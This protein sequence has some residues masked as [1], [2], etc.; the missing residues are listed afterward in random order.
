MQKR[1][2]IKRT[3]QATR[4]RRRTQICRVYQLKLT[5]NKLRRATRAHL[6][7]LFQE[8]KWF[9]NWALSGPD[10]FAID[11]TRKTVPVKVGS[12]F[13]ERPLRCLSSQMKQGLVTQLHHAVSALITLKTQGQKV[14]RLK[15]KKRV[16]CIPL[17]QA[18]VTYQ[19]TPKRTHPPPQPPRGAIGLDP[20]LA[21]QFAFSNG[22]AITYRVR[23]PK[24]LR[25]LYRQ[26]SRTQKGSRNREKIRQKIE[27]QYH[28]LN[29]IKRDIRNQLVAYLEGHYP[30][31][32]FQDETLRA[33]HRLWGKKMLDLSLGAFFRVLKQR[34]QT[35][36]ELPRDFPSTQLC[37]ACGH[38]QK[39]RLAE[40]V[41]H[42]PTCG[43][44]LDRDHNAARNL[45]LAGWEKYQVRQTEPALGPGRIEVTPAEIAAATQ[46]MVE[47]LDGL[48]HVHASRVVEPGSLR[49][50]A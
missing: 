49:A 7:C 36:V 42:C 40:R 22:V 19:P 8:A 14:G 37:S 12:T 17:K 31:V 4:T 24:R 48:P 9:T 15:Y 33:W 2:T 38:R 50:S 44:T 3:L 30:V 39:V 47:H 29:N 20:G 32:C 21:S 46:Q 6:R 23:I 28:Q 25:R 41:Y 16:Q 35:P 10:L 13:E 27:K 1:Q 45:L 18:G 11:T 26:F 43:L 34:C 5:R